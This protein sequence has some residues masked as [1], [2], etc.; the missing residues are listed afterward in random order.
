[1]ADLRLFYHEKTQKIKQTVKKSPRR[2]ARV[3]RFKCNFI[4]EKDEQRFRVQD[5]VKPSVQGIDIAMYPA[6]QTEKADFRFIKRIGPDGKN[7]VINCVAHRV[8][9]LRD[10]LAKFCRAQQRC[11]SLRLRF[12][13]RGGLGCQPSRFISRYA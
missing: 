10:G 11:Q 13:Q 12:G 1:M 2:S 3:L 7:A 9:F 8:G 5:A 4:F 6:V